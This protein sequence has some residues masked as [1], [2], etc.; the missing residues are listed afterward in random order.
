MLLVCDVEDDSDDR[1]TRIDVRVYNNY[2][3]ANWMGQLE[4]EICSTC[5]DQ[6]QP[7]S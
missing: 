3:S 1:K 2:D 7:L 6:L 4:E 5:R